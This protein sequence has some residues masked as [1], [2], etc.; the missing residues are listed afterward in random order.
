MRTYI[1]KEGEISREWVVMDAADQVLGRLAT[2]VASILRGKNKPDFTPHLDTG[3]F[4]VIV[5]AER[6]KLTGAKLDDKVYYRHSGR[7]GSL[8]SETARE[9]LDKHPERVIQAAVWG[10]LPKNR[11]GRKL[12]KKLKVYAGPEHPHEAQQPK[13]HTL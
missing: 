9:R 6:V 1:P 10:M 8:K 7:P 4:V 13:T 11:L 12:L 2:E 3:D 5:N